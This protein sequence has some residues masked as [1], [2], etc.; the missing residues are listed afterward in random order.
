MRSIASLRVKIW[1]ILDGCPPEYETLFRDIVHSADLV[2]MPYESIGNRATF[3]KQIDLLLEQQEADVIYFAEDDY[4]YLPDQFAAMLQFLNAHSDV[5]FI[6]PIDH[7]DSYTLELHRKPEWIRIGASHHWR[8]VSS[9]CVTFLTRKS[10]LARS[11]TTFRT[12]LR[13]NDDCAI[14]LSLTKGRVFNP[15]ALG[16]Y[17]ATNAFGWRS[18]LKAWL[19]GWRRILFEEKLSLWAPIPAIAAHLA[20]TTLS[21]NC[22]WYDLVHLYADELK[23]RRDLAAVLENASHADPSTFSS[24]I[25]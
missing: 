8:T 22:N 24:S 1:A 14:W 19:Y 15:V 3:G 17:L 2:V 13:R 9:S 11:A 7:M 10:T 18:M 6:T 25:G 16:H 5:D 12:Y 20:P 21:P 4:F 23:E